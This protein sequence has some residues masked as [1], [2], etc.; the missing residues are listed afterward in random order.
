MQQNKGTLEAIST[1]QACSKLL[2]TKRDQLS[3]V[4]ARHYYCQK[5]VSTT[6]GDDTKVEVIY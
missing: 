3:K 4:T 5:T 1:F 2:L 6:F